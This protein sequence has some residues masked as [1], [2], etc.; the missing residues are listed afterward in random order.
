MLVSTYAHNMLLHRL[1][2]HTDRVINRIVQLEEEAINMSSS[3]LS[4]VVLSYLTLQSC[5]G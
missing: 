4:W 1:L 3:V 2:E 5:F